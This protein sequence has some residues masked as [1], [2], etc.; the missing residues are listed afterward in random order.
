MYNPHMKVLQLNKAGAP[1]KWISPERAVNLYFTDKIL[2]S[3]SDENVT[4]RGG[5]NRI[6]GLR[7]F[8]EIHTIIAVRGEINEK[9]FT[10]DAGTKLDPNATYWFVIKAVPKHFHDSEHVDSA[11]KKVVVEE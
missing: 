8:M 1:L 9:Q 7:S 4:L 5:T 6:T 3:M 10:Y 2:W 11:F